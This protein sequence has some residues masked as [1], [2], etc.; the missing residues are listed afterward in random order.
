MRVA[1]HPG[2]WGPYIQACRASAIHVYTDRKLRL[3]ERLSRCGPGFPSGSIDWLCL[4]RFDSAACFAAL[5]VTPEQGRWL[6][7]PAATVRDTERHYRDGT[8]ILETTFST[9]DGEVTLIDFM[10]P[11][12]NHPDIIRIVAGKRGRV[13][14]HLELIIR[15]DYGSIVPWVH[16]AGKSLYAMAG[17]DALRLDIG[18]GLRG[19]NLH[20]VADFTVR[21]GDRVAFLLCSFWLADNWA[22]QGDYGKA[23]ALFERLLSLR[24]DVGLLSEEY[25]MKPRRFLGNFPQALSHVAMI[26][27]AYNLLRP[28]GPARHRSRA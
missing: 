21:E 24:N 4:P 22:M 10:P 1:P 5:L 20:T 26:N 11:R 25:D 27:T 13:P 17:P 28:E 3:S 9:D 2:R 15:F 14:M 7:S 23:T 12:G 19:E 16:R 8:L 18:V 6:L